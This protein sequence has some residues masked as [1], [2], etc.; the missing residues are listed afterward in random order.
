MVGDPARSR[1]VETRWS[2]WSFSTQ[3]ILW[4]YDSMKC[5]ALTVYP[6]TRVVLT[7]KKSASELAEADDRASYAFIHVGWLQK[8][9]NI[10]FTLHLSNVCLIRRKKKICNIVFWCSGVNNWMGENLLEA[11][12]DLKTFPFAE[13]IHCVRTHL[14]NC[15]GSF[16]WREDIYLDHKRAHLQAGEQW[17]GNVLINTILNISIFERDWSLFHGKVR[18]AIIFQRRW[19]ECSR[20]PSIKC[21]RGFFWPRFWTHCLLVDNKSLRI[22]EVLDELIQIS[23]IKEKDLFLQDLIWKCIECWGNA[24]SDSRNVSRL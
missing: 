14:Q 16:L 10:G 3:T 12:Y 21:D 9:G 2:L 22:L 13:P 1:G 6:H 23:L 5:S 20:R 15:R 24:R 11:V 18:R 7:S 8:T 17:Q 19:M 4:F